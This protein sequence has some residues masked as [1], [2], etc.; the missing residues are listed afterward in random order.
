MEQLKHVDESVW[1]NVN[2]V[3]EPTV[4]AV[5]KKRLPDYQPIYQ[6][7]SCTKTSM[8]TNLYSDVTYLTLRKQV[9]R[10]VNAI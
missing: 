3:R 10:G 5:K 6:P 4:L 7:T 9:R 1:H 2:P 8:S